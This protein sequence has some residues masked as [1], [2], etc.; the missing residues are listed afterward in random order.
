VRE[1]AFAGHALISLGR[2]D[3]DSLP[4][5]P[6]VYLF[7]DEAERIIY[8]G[9]AGSLRKRVKSYFTGSAPDN[10]RLA[11]L[12]ASVRGIDYIIT[13]NQAEALLLENTL[14]KKYHP[15]YNIMLRD[16]KSYP[17]IGITVSEEYPRAF[18]FRGTRRRDTVYYGPFWHAG[19]AR[20]T[21]DALRKVFPF[22]TCP[23]PRPGRSRGNPCLDYHI[24]LCPGP[25]RGK[26]D[27]KEYAESI[28]H[29]REFLG[30]R[31]DQVLTDLRAKMQRE[32]EREEFEKAA[33]TRDALLALERI[34]EKQS[35][36]SMRNVDQ[37]VIGLAA[38]ELDACITVLFIRSGLLSGK[39]EFVFPR[40]P[41]IADENVV[42]SFIELYYETAPFV[43]GEVLTPLALGS[44]EEDLL[45][46]WMTEQR[47]RRVRV[48]H[49]QR[50]RKRD[51]VRKAEEN[52]ASYLEMVKLKRGSD[53]QWLS[54]V[55]STLTRDLL[56]SHLPYRIECY[57]IS[58]LG[59]D[60]VVGAMVVFE[61]GL[62][63]RR[64]YRKF[65]ILSE[66][67]DDTARMSEVLRRRL[68]KM[69]PLP[70]G[71]DEDEGREA[72]LSRLTSFQKVPDL[73]LIDGGKGQLNAAVRTLKEK[74][75][76]GVEVASLAKSLECIYRPGLSQPVILP[77]DSRALYLLQRIRD[78]AH[79]FA[80]TYHRS[81]R[82]SKARAS[83]L[84]GVPGIGKAR[85]ASLMG[86][87]GSVERMKK[88]S[89]EELESLSF[90]DRRSAGNLYE[91][92]HG[93][94]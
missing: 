70:P 5:S 82:E 56:L 79:R 50:G 54:E 46:K 37:D 14:I 84:D 6:G 42:T 88:A 76:D 18:F 72:K 26:V 77:R 59:P 27:R 48:M 83:V 80:I 57:D 67:A 39:R 17:Y 13:A 60:E 81:L 8:V 45:G 11:Q 43:P 51:L 38:D 15:G 94:G 35:V 68:D 16:D 24:Q 19:S 21:L 36:Y 23:G 40:P 92:L 53:L 32:A 12:R 73:I 75:V 66:A 2:D 85:K 58:N 61:G 29:I 64:D 31:Q 30:G 71:G 33:R 52:A 74:C 41:E 87:Y 47:D 78:E 91:T 62:P 25:C 22:R 69:T 55:T 44:E 10:P 93:G 3:A 34:L 89:R 28:A 90:L 4:E 65:L 20:E 63:L 1:E 86:R 49:P 9:K 7:K